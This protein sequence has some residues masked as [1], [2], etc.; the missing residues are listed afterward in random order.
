MHA[1]KESF[2]NPLIVA[3]QGFLTEYAPP[4]I[5]IMG[6][7]PWPVMMA[8]ETLAIA[9]LIRIQADYGVNTPSPKS[10]M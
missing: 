8:I 1:L 7:H 5:Y 9:V 4:T 3:F 2:K 6:C 10:L